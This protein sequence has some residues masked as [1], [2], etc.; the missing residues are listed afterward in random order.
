MDQME[1]G[2]HV[3][4]AYTA[5]FDFTERGTTHAGPEVA[6]GE[7]VFISSAER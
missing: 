3:F 4:R 7:Y 2:H 1:H 5:G 6:R